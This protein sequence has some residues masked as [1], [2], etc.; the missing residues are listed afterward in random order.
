M[1]VN[2]YSIRS[3]GLGYLLDQFLTLAFNT[4]ILLKFSLFQ[5]VCLPFTLL[6]SVGV[7]LSLCLVTTLSEN[8]ITCFLLLS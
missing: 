4:W 7:E 1:G 8:V 3:S 6:V 5:R 2:A